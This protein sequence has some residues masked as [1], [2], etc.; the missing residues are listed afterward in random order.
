MK[1][2]KYTANALNNEIHERDSKWLAF[3]KIFKLYKLRLNINQEKNMGKHHEYPRI[4]KSFQPY[5]SFNFY[6]VLYPYFNFCITCIHSWC[7]MPLSSFKYFLDIL[8]PF[9]FMPLTPFGYHMEEKKKKIITLCLG[10]WV[11]INTC[12]ILGPILGL[13]G[14]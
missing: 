5:P 9:E 11:Y 8:S 4:R 6:I 13:K 14:K 7:G 1:G 3:R 10:V 2:S 12:F